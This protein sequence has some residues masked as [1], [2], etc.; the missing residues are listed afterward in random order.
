MYAALERPFDR[1]IASRVAAQEGV[2][3]DA[4]ATE[5][6]ADAAQ[7]AAA[8]SEIVD[9]LLGMMVVPSWA[10]LLL[11]VSSFLVIVVGALGAWLSA[12]SP[13]IATYLRGEASN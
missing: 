7:S 11:F 1:F 5:F 6:A 2:A 8:S 3:E 4:A 12:R 10:I 9:R 13:D